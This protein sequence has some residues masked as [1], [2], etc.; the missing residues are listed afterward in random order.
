MEKSGAS[1]SPGTL[2]WFEEEQY[3]SKINVTKLQQQVEQF[4]AALW[5]QLERIQ[6]GEQALAAAMAQLARMPKLEE[7]L[8]QF[9]E[10]AAG[11]QESWL[12][13]EER[14]GEEERGHLA[15]L[16]RDR[17][18]RGEAGRKLELLEREAQNLW[19]K[20]S[21]LEDGYRRSAA[22]FL[23]LQQRTEGLVHEDQRLEARIHGLS[24]QL[25]H[26]EQELDRFR[27]EQEAL[28]KQ[29]E[30]T[31]GRLHILGEQIK[32]LQDHLGAVRGAEQLQQEIQERLELQRLEGQRLERQNA[33]IQ[34]TQEEQHS[35][36]EDL[37]RELNQ[38][39]GKSQTLVEHLDQV[40]EQMWGVREEIAQQFSQ[41]AQKEEQQKRR[42]IAELEQQIRELRGR[43]HPT[44]S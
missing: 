38:L 11:L 16:E 7:E 20:L 23:E 22:S 32:E 24:E 31:S 8:R 18:A 42:Q 14:R 37:G 13:L 4:Q 28:R 40:R 17:Q 36:L 43:S 10:V 29:D 35:L 12:K 9:R 34:T 2:Q 27:Q 30:V 3:R 26:G 5:D 19:T 1:T 44:G 21:A 41:L 33:D 6:Q 25:R 15:E 39:S